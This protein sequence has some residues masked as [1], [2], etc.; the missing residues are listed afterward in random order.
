MLNGNLISIQEFDVHNSVSIDLKI[1]ENEIFWGENI[2]DIKSLDRF[3]SETD[4]LV[5]PPS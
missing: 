2:I 3:L 1:N 4:N 5:P